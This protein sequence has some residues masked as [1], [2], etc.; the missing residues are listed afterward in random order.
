MKMA[1][2][3]AIAIVLASVEIAANPVLFHNDCDSA[4][5]VAL[6]YKSSNSQWVTTSWYHFAPNEEARLNLNTSNRTFYYYARGDAGVWRGSR[7]DRAD[8]TFT[9]SGK[10]LRFKMVKF[11][12]SSD[13]FRFALHCPSYNRELVEEAKRSATKNKATEVKVIYKPYLYKHIW[14]VDYAWYPH[15][16]V[17]V[18]DPEKKRPG[19][20]F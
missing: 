10:R 17:V 19:V 1:T 3:V 8:R 5:Q 2:A 13:Q 6:R 9:V 11:T 15:V 18:V 16:Y 7:N 20:L 4:V 14:F 12:K